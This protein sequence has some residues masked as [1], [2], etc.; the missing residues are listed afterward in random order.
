MNKQYKEVRKAAKLAGIKTA[1]EEQY[2]LY[3]TNNGV[4]VA[5]R[6]A[7]K[8]SNCRMLEVAV[9]YCALEDDFDPK[10]G[11]FHARRK[12]L[13][14]EYIQLPLAEYLR[15]NGVDETRTLLLEL[16]QL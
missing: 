2:K 8:N 1:S 5:F 16:F 9:S 3:R 10:V 15:D 11:K 7:I 4:T 6:L 13:H 12:L 14:G